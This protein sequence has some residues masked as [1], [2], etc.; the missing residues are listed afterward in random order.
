VTIL[1]V[2]PDYSGIYRPDDPRFLDFLPGELERMAGGGNVSITVNTVSA[3]A[4]LPNLIVDALQQ[5]NLVSGPLD[6]QIAV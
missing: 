3:D 6:V 4:N 1:P 5:Y 2:T